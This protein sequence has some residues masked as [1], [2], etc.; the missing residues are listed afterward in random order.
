MP[1]GQRAANSVVRG[2]PWLPADPTQPYICMP[3]V[4]MN[5][6]VWARGKPR[7]A[8]DAHLWCAQFEQWSRLIAFDWP[9]SSTQQNHKTTICS[10]LYVSIICS[11][12]Q[13]KPR[14][15]SAITRRP[16][17]RPR[18]AN[19]VRGWSLTEKC[20]EKEGCPAPL[21]GRVRD[22]RRHGS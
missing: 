17:E 13:K 1:N 19:G 8:Q 11:H 4:I 9:H 10:R 6:P 14:R 20:G 18:C 16:S 22:S 3:T 7:T 12:F 21:L 5:V 15:R 2:Y